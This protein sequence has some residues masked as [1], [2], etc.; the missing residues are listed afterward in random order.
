MKGYV[1][2]LLLALCLVVT[3]QGWQTRSKVGET[4]DRARAAVCSDGSTCL[5]ARDEP[6]VVRAD[7]LSRQ[8]QFA[9]N[10]GPS[11]VTC[12]RP[13]LLFGDFQCQAAPGSFKLHP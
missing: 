12:T 3:Y 9:T 10:K 13:Y 1:G 8:Y 11:T 2:W 4:Q 7:F 5:L 6:T